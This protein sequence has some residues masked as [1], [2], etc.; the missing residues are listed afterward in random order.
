[1][2]ITRRHARVTK[3]KKISATVD[4]S[5]GNYKKH[6]FFVKK[7]KAAKAILD[8]VGLPKKSQKNK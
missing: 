6:P 5:V 2:A 8:E 4:S 3:K 1:M 7:A